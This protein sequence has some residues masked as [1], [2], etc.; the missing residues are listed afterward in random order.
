[1]AKDRPAPLGKRILMAGGFGAFY[2]VVCWAVFAVDGHSH[3]TVFGIG[4]G[5]AIGYWCGRDDEREAGA[6]G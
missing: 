1:M 2:A 5:A 6:D 4:V 3:A